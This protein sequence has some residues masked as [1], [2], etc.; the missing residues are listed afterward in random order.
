MNLAITGNVQELRELVLGGYDQLFE[1]VDSAGR[2]LMEIAH[3]YGQEMI[4]HFLSEAMN[5]VDKREW[6]HKAIRVGSLPHVQYIADTEDVAV[7]KDSKG[8]TSLHLATLCEETEIMKF[9]AAQYPR[10]LMIGDNLER[11]PLHYAM[12]VE[13]VDRVAKVL[14]QA[15][16]RRAMRDLRGRTPSSLFIR[17]KEVRDMQEED[18]PPPR[19]S[20]YPLPHLPD[21][22]AN[23]P[24]PTPPPGLKAGLSTVSP[25]P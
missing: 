13:G 1:V 19:P 5:F 16:A 14:V 23:L 10:L 3:L 6:L 8:R 15:G 11:T 25:P 24:P 2:N 18:P 17:P 22:P 4:V 20:S 7:A 9:L 21:L 12:A